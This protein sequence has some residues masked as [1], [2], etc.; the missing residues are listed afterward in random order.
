MRRNQWC[1]LHMQMVDV[2][3]CTLHKYVC[4]YVHFK[5]SFY[6][7]PPFDY[8][9]ILIY[10]PISVFMSAHM[11]KHAQRDQRSVL[12]PLDLEFQACMSLLAWM[13]GPLQQQVFLTIEPLLQL[14]NLSCSDRVSQ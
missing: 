9:F 3:M 11:H 13:L 7:S 4:S 1:T 6:R 8:L 10:V 5:Y 12:V 14:L 2:C